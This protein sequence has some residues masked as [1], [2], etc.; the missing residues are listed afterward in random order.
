MITFTIFQFY[1]LLLFKKNMIQVRDIYLETEPFSIE[2]NLLTPTMKSKRP[3]L[4]NHY[5]EQIESLYA[6]LD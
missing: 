4:K 5:L 2:N 3:M 6:N 1:L